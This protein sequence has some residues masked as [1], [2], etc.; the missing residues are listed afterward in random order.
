MADPGSSVTLIFYKISP[1]WWKEPALNLMAAVEQMSSYCHVEIGIGA[2]VTLSCHRMLRFAHHTFACAFTG[3]APGSGGQIANV[4]RVYNDAVGVELTERTGRNPCNTY[5][6]LG[7]SKL[8][9]Q[10]ML[11]YAKKQVGKPFSNQG[12]V[13]SLV[14]PRTTT[15]ESFFCAGAFTAPYCSKHLNLSMSINVNNPFSY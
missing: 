2:R 9:E 8:A 15:E 6:S 14:W 10:R 1:Q 7:C 12:M 4:A 13:R 5:L 11:A 3:E